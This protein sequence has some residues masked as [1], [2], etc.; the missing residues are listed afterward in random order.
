[1]K[2]AFLHFRENVAEKMKIITKLAENY[3]FLQ[4]LAHEISRECDSENFVPALIWHLCFYLSVPDVHAD[5]AGGPGGGGLVVGGWWR[6]GSDQG[7]Q[8]RTHQVRQVGQVAGV[9]LRHQL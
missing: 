1:M 9:H 7:R 6:A 3:P 2:N 8:L 5:A 4:I